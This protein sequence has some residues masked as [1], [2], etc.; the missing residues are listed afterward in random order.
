MKI[1]KTLDRTW[2]RQIRDVGVC[3]VVG[4]VSG[5]GQTLVAQQVTCQAVEFNWRLDPN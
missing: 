5:S 4:K 3:G 2:K 1:K